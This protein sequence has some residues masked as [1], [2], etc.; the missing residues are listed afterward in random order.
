M[1]V[2]IGREILIFLV[3]FGR[4]RSGNFKFSVH[5]LV[6]IGRYKS[7]NFKF[8]I[9]SPLPPQGI[10]RGT[11]YHELSRKLHGKSQKIT[12]MDGK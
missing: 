7:G 4:Y 9:R 8:S 1:S 5:L 6:G 11:Y 3:S 2:G 12:E 10:F